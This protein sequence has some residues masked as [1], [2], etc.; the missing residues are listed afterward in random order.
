MIKKL[1]IVRVKRVT[2]AVLGEFSAFVKGEPIAVSPVAWGDEC[3]PSHWGY[4]LDGMKYGDLE[5]LCAWSDAFH[6]STI[7]SL[8]DAKKPITV[9]TALASVGLQINPSV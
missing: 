5:S 4:V 6:H 9:E 3:G 1:V 8:G 7:L 2:P